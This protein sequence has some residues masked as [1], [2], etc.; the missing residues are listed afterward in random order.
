MTLLQ[1]T[2]NVLSRLGSDEVNSISDTV[3]SMQVARIIQNKYFDIIS[4]G[5]VPENEQL[6]QLVPSTDP[7]QPTLMYIPAGVST[8]RWIK[9]FD[10]N[11]SD[12]QQV[13]Q[14]GSFSHGLNLDLVSSTTFTTTST[15]SN[16]I[17]TGT[18]TFI[19]ADSGLPITTGQ[20]I[21]AISGTASMFG[22]VTSY[23]GTTLVMNSTSTIGSGTFTS[24]TLTNNTSETVAGY[25]YVTLQGID[26]FLDTINR[27]NPSESN[28]GSFTFAEGGN[29][30][31]FYY[32]NDI[33]PS[34]ATVIANRYVIFDS[35]DNTFDSTLQGSK[36]LCYGELTPAFTM[37]DSSVPTMDDKWFPLLLNEATSVAFL[38]LKQMQHPKADQEIR[39]QW[40][41]V[42]KKGMV[43]D[44]PSYFD[45]L[46]N[47]GRVPRTGGYSSGGYGAYK[48]MRESGP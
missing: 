19:I 28:V 48:W 17:G 35:Y 22:T 47:F 7:T 45:S 31:T 30:F 1:L 46:A 24:W 26:Q 36:T 5:L 11:P 33:Q 10:S 13:S 25:K 3:E 32:K 43:S 4:R 2:Q 39:R 8:L 23:I 16:T 38:E 42:Q 41:V 18:K 9:Y 40:S 6:Y 29:N 27:F 34:I 20:G 15:T 14:F 12:S 44:K 37:V 21:M